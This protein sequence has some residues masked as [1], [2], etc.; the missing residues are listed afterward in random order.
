M[1]EDREATRQFE[2]VEIAP[3]ETKTIAPAGELARPGSFSR[4]AIVA[5]DPSLVRLVAGLNALVEYPYGCTEQRL[6]LARGGLALKASGQFSR[7][8]GL[9]IA[10]PPM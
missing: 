9:R 7:R 3:G 10:S 4:E 2:L 8:R 5:A 1:K 6:S